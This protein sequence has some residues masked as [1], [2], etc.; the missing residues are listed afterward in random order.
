MAGIPTPIGA[1]EYYDSLPVGGHQCG[2]IW[3]HLPTHGV[4]RESHLSALVITPACD[5]ANRKVETITYLPIVSV[6]RYLSSRAFLPDLLRS[7]EGQMKSAGAD[8]R[9]RT[10]SL[11]GPPS[12]AD[13]TAA[14]AVLR[15]HTAGRRLGQKEAGAA[16]RAERGLTLVSEILAGQP[17]GNPVDAIRALLGEK[18]WESLLQRIILN[19]ARTD[20]HFLPSDGQRAGWSAIPS[21]SVV[22]FRYPLS[23]PIDLLDLATTTEPDTWRD[24]LTSVASMHPC[25]LSVRDHRPI[26][27]LRV[28]Q[29]FVSDILTRFTGLYGRLGS[30]DFTVATVQRYLAEIGAP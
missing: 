27:L 21:H 22:L 26:K 6:S 29:R 2:D 30:P 25:A 13:V 23:L 17:V 1:N 4:L 18:E 14:L 9:L 8:L 10:D 15:E 19:G 12:P 16:E 20:I 24:A 5:L 11:S 7:V 28:R 3:A